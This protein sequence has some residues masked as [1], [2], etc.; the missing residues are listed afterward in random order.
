MVSLGHPVMLAR[1]DA[2][3]VKVADAAHWSTARICAPQG[4]ARRVSHC[5]AQSAVGIGHV[6]LPRAHTPAQVAALGGC[7]VGG[8]AG[9]LRTQASSAICCIAQ[10]GVV[11]APLPSHTTA[12]EARQLL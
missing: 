3:H 4:P 5:D 10:L 8:G 2:L 1:P 9:G 7:C 6:A 12:A 11:A